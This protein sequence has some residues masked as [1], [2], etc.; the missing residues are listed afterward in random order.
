MNILLSSAGRRVA[1]TELFRQALRGRGRVIAA[2]A[3]PTA[4]ALYAADKGILVPR[5]DDVAYVP[6]ILGICRA[7]AVSAIVPLI[8]TELPTLAQAHDEFRNVGTRLLAAGPDSIETC[9]DKLQTAAFFERLGIATPQTIPRDARP[10]PLPAVIKPRRGSSGKGVNIVR[11]ASEVDYWLSNTPDPLIQELLVGPEVTTDVL[12]DLEGKPVLAVQRERLKTR[13]GEVERGVTVNYPGI[14]ECAL[15]AAEA[16]RSAGVINVQ[17]FLT[18]R[19]PLFTE[20][21]PRF[22]GGYPL[23]HAAGAAF[24]ERIVAMLAREPQPELPAPRAGMVMMRFDQ[25]VFRTREE[26]LT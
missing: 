26:L 17:C 18:K 14:T 9:F 3:D 12:C 16:L 6:A 1:L 25:A 8:D 7:E 19:G 13:G 22:G 5:A 15:R 21:N 11:T 24:P 10:H 23:A 4:P 20:I 2:D